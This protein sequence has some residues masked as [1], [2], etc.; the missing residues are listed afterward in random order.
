MRKRF[1]NSD[2][3]EIRFYI[4]GMIISGTVQ[5]ILSIVKQCMFMMTYSQ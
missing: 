2:E 3:Q 4:I 5:L 1:F